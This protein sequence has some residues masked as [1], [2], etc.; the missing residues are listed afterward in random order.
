MTQEAHELPQKALALPDKE[1]AELVGNLIAGLDATAD[2]DVD[3]A[4]REEIAHRLQDVQS[5]R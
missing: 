4:W 2:Q 1:R 3:A 5:D